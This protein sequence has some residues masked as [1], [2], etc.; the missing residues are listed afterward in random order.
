MEWLLTNLPHY[1]W[2]DSEHLLRGL[3]SL[4][5]I[6]LERAFEIALEQP[7]DESASGMEYALI[8]ELMRNGQLEGI[9]PLLKRVRE[10]KQFDGYNVMGLNL[11]EI[12][13]FDEA[14]TLGSQ[15]PESK[16]PD[17]FR[18]LTSTGIWR[19][20]ELFIAKMSELPNKEIRSDVARQIIGIVD[21]KFYPSRHSISDTDLR[22]IRSLITED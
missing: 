20:S 15:L 3:I 19:N 16:W 14:F 12:G 7:K 13:K 17:Y 1:D 8:V 9:E 4:G 2:I 22:Y 6:D 11:I 5:S 21:M 10:P 18:Q